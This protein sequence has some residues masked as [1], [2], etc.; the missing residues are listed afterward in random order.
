MCK[1]R[2]QRFKD[3]VPVFP[4]TKYTKKYLKY[5]SHKRVVNT[6][7][8]APPKVHKWFQITFCLL[9][10]IKIILLTSKNSIKY[11]LLYE[12]FKN[13]KIFLRM[14]ELSNFR[15][16]LCKKQSQ[17]STN[18]SYTNIQ[19][20]ENPSAC[21]RAFSNIWFFEKVLIFTIPTYTSLI[22]SMLIITKEIKILRFKYY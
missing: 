1:E 5:L 18:K 17:H 11:H 21:C 16:Q 3:T 4:N 10:I 13:S 8:R 15:E 7:A 2:A 6:V 20:P 19:W 9:K 12:H 22:S 14:L